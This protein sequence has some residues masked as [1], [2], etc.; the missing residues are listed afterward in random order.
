[1]SEHTNEMWRLASRP[2]GMLSEDNF[3]WDTAPV[4]ELTDGQILV[5]TIY[6]SID[7]SNRIWASGDSYMPAVELGDVMRGA[8]LGVVEASKHDAFSAGDLVQGML[9]WQRYCVSDGKGMVP[10]PKGM[11]F[12]LDS[13]VAVLNHIGMTAYVGMIEI[14]EPAEG[15]TV[16]VSAAAGAVGSIAGQLAKLQGA[17]VVGIC[18]SD[19]KCAWLTGELGF[20]GA[21]NRRTEDIPARLRELCPDG[22]DVYFDNTGGPILDAALA[23]MNLHGRIPLC[24]LISGYNL[25]EPQPGPKN[26]PLILLR[27]LRVQGFIVLDHMDR[28]MQILMQL[29]QWIG[30]GKLSYRVDLVDGLRAAPSALGRLFSGDNIGKLAVKVSDEP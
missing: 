4:P 29:G 7:P 20:D 27:R 10:L 28:A 14:G 24:G 23:R 19:E 9:G 26:Y 21:I 3:R 11:P 17:R 5:R 30:T 1:M 12:P 13:S 6:L 15:D 8:G 2:E 16:L 25:E 18:G 22:I